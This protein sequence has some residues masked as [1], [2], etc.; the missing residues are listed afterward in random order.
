MG[1]VF[2]VKLSFVYHWGNSLF[3]IE[4]KVISPSGNAKLEICAKLNSRAWKLRQNMDLSGWTSSRV[5]GSIV[6]GLVKCQWALGAV[7]STLVLWPYLLENCQFCS[8]IKVRLNE[9]A[10][11]SSSTWLYRRWNSSAYCKNW[12]FLKSIHDWLKDN[13]WHSAGLLKFSRILPLLTFFVSVSNKTNPFWLPESRKK[14]WE[15]IETKS[16]KK[17]TWKLKDAKPKRKLKGRNE[18]ELK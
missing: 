16:L 10:G 12:N 4:L 8:L 17:K 13:D 14:M 2:H 3:L 9:P 11:F 15:N 6:S 7:S 18:K 1:K 5:Y